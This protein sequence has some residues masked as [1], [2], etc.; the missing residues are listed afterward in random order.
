MQD[1][2][3]RQGCCGNKDEPCIDW[4]LSAQLDNSEYAIYRYIR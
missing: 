2:V 4:F 1:R 3:D